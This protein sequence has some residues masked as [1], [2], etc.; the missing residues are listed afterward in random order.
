MGRVPWVSALLPLSCPER[1]AAC[2]A[3]S[4]RAS[5]ASPIAI[6]PYPGGDQADRD[7]REQGWPRRGTGYPSEVTIDTITAR[8][9]LDEELARLRTSLQTVSGAIG[10]EETG[11]SDE[12]SSADQHP[13]E[14]GTEVNDLSRDVGLR[15]DLR[16][17]IEE[18][19]AARDR[20]DAGRY[21]M[22]ERCGRPIAADRLRDMPSTRCCVEDEALVDEG[23]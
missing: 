21:G 17:R 10:D 8:R 12:L 1:A 18:N 16:R 9:L 11:A 2:T 23:R 15:T 7:G 4:R 6:G 19:A 13:A 20:L 14:V 5:P 3:W 22:C